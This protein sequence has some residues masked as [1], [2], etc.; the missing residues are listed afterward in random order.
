ME[1]FRME[2][3]QFLRYAGSTGVGDALPPRWDAEPL[4]LGS[5]G[6]IQVI[7]LLVG[8]H[9]LHGLHFISRAGDLPTDLCW[10]GVSI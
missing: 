3:Q 5:S 6:G 7:Q 1:V 4:L 2:L 9:G 8:L 10:G